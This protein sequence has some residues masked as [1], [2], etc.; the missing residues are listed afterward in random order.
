MSEQLTP[1]PFCDGRAHLRSK[2]WPYARWW[3]W[4]ERCHVASPARNTEAK[5]IAAWNARPGGV[6]A[7]GSVSIPVE[8]VKEALVEAREA[9]SLAADVPLAD[10]YILTDLRALCDRV[11]YG[12]V[13]SSASALWR[14]KLGE[15]KGGEFCAGPCRATAEAAI[16]LI[17]Q[18]L[19]LLPQLQ[20]EEGGAAN[21]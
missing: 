18:A 14:E 16:E 4:C 9:L 2:Q 5:A 1:C 11:G 10:P 17:D 21:G 20:S 12:N 15:L 3:T 7:M 19:S 13:M 6:A 8:R